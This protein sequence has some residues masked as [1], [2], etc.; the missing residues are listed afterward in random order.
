MLASAKAERSMD[1]DAP[2]RGRGRGVETSR[3]HI[4]LPEE[5]SD[6]LAEIQKDTF[7]SSVTEVIKN[8]LLVYAG[9][10]EDHKSGKKFYTIDKN[11]DKESLRIFL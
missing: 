4:T 1:A 11:N 3:V 6:R 8:A 7:A 9:L 2:R 10:L 5:L